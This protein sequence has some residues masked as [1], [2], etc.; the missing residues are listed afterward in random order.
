[1]HLPI[2]ALLP[3]LLTLPLTSAHLELIYPPSRAFNEDTLSTFPCGGQNTP[4]ATRTPWS[5]SGGP[6]SLKMGHTSSAVQVLL[7]LGN[8]PGSAFNIVLLPTM[9]ENAPGSFCIAGVTGSIPAS[10]G[11]RDGDN[12]TLQVVSNGDPAGGLYNVSFTYCDCRLVGHLFRA[13]FG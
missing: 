2:T 11:I 5:L 6:I 4:S 1:M 13:D 3:L 12:A 10:L 8:D 7:G 9:Q